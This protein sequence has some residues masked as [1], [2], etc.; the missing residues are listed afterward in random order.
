MKIKIEDRT[1]KGTGVEIMEE[2]RNL[3]FDPDEYGGTEGYIRQIQCN[4]IRSTG[5]DCRLPS[6][7]R[8]KMARAMFAYLAEV[9]ALE[10]LDDG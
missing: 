8:E 3:S 6:G 2:L 1:Y 9:D 10:I 4:Y 5:R 7:D